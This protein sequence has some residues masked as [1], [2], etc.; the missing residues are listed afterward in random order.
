MSAPMHLFQA[1]GVEIEYMIVDEQTLDVKPVA[2]RLIH[3]TGSVRK[4]EVSK[5][6][7]KWSNEL[8]S[9]VIEVKTA[10]PVAS[11][12]SLAS[13]IQDQVRVIEGQLKPLGCRLLPSGMHP[14]MDPTSETVLWP[15]D[16]REIYE[17]FDRIFGCKGH[18]WSNLQS[19]HINLAFHGDEEFRKLHS[20]IRLVLP[21]IPALAAS[22][23]FVEGAGAPCLD[24]RLEAYRNN[25]ARFPSV[26]ARLIPDVIKSKAKYQTKI[27]DPIAKDLKDVEADDVLD[28]IW[29]N[30]RGA[31]AR[32]D[33][34]SVEIRLMDAQ[35]CPAADLAIVQ[36]IVD[37]L[38]LLTGGR[39]STLESQEAI[40]TDFLADLLSQT[41]QHAGQALLAN[42]QY[43]ELFGLK[44]NSI[45]TV[46]ELLAHLLEIVPRAH[47]SSMIQAI[48]AQGS[49]A[50]RLKRSVT[51]ATDSGSLL[52]TYR[53]LA[54]CLRNGA[55]LHA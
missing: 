41:I 18:G 13:G 7:F 10:G 5:G 29:V 12:D 53:E 21:L 14:W 38:R 43:I 32:F 39:C 36:F 45:A 22:S 46:K 15:H 49:L 25:C 54:D 24:Q 27:Y 3:A 42:T 51:D 37:L 33:R 2:D 28:P 48:L 26:T 30:A 23:P 6:R 44:D 20:A 52:S 19:T 16:D 4:N 1:F 55:M 47:K 11:L 31:I 17:T 40:P 34:G 9:H 35:E 50:E 8:V